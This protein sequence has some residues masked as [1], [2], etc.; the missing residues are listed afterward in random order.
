[1][2]YYVVLKVQSSFLIQESASNLAAYSKF[3]SLIV[4][5]IESNGLQ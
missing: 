1:M 5:D 3:S 2:V 4:N